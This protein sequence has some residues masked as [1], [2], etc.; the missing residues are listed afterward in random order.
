LNVPP[1]SSTSAIVALDVYFYLIGHSVRPVDAIKAM[2]DFID[3]AIETP[4]DE[5]RK[6]IIDVPT[7][8]CCL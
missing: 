1:A 6:K 8:P 3:E 5:R 2:T 4:H 7:V